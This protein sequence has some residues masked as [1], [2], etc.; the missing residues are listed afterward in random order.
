MRILMLV[1]ANDDNGLYSALQDEWRRYMKSSKDIDC[2]FIKGCPE[3]LDQ[4]IVK[5]E[6]IYFKIYEGYDKNDSLW[7]KTLSAF[8]YFEP[9]FNEYTFIYRTNLSTHIHFKKY[10]EFC[11]ILPTSRLCAALINNNHGYL[12]PSGAGFTLSMDLAKRLLEDTPNHYIM[13]DVTVGIA[14]KKWNIQIM[15]TPRVDFTDTI[16]ETEINKRILRSDQRTFHFRVKTNEP[17]RINKD[18]FIHRVL[19]N[20]HYTSSTKQ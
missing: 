2:Y 9:R 17:N 7:Q 12:Y 16:T 11:K 8:R 10:L 20:K 6:S 19:C 13:D 18:I 4:V 1:L 5:D 14:L 15:P 3:Q